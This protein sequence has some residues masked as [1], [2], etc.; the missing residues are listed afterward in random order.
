MTTF[1]M[2]NRAAP[3]VSVS[4][5]QCTQPTPGSLLVPKSAAPRFSEALL[6]VAAGG[7]ERRMNAA[8]STVSPASPVTGSVASSGVALYWQPAAVARSLGKSSL[9]TPCSTLYASP[10][11]MSSDLFCAF[12]PKRV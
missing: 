4:V 10:A 9:E 3:V 8:N 6:V 11:K 5:W 2:P 7:A 1:D 12:Q